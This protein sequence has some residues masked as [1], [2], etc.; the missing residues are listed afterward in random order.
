LPGSYTHLLSIQ[1][2]SLPQSP[3]TVELALLGF[4]RHEPRHGYD[5]NRRL[6]ETPELRLI[7]RMKQSRLYALLAR[8]EEEGLIQATLEPQDGRPP[9]KVY[10]MTPD[11]EIAFTDWLARPVQLPREMRL[12]FMLKLYFAEQEG[13]AAVARLIQD[14]QLVCDGWLAAQEEDDVVSTAFVRAVRGY[15]RSHIRAIRDWLAW[16]AIDLAVETQPVE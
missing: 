14:Q 6:T 9:R 4:V 7:W 3:L 12:E 1:F 8:L 13:Q 15:R 2:M 11:G 10:H 16:L 5:I